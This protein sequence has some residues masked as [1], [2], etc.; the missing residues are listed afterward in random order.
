MTTYA[1]IR[2]QLDKPELSGDDIFGVARSLP[3]TFRDA[4]LLRLIP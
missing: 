1:A 2:A 3:T 4:T